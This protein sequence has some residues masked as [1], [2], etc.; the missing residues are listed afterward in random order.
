MKNFL[1]IADFDKIAIENLIQKA[2]IFKQENLFYNTYNN[3]IIVNL[4]FED[5]TR[6]RTSFEMAELRLGFRTIGFNPQTSSTNKGE[7]LED[8]CKTM[9]SIGVN[10]LV[11]RHFKN[12]FYDELKD[13]QIP[14]INAGDGSGEHPSQCL[15]DLLTI[16]EHFGYFDG[17]KVAIVGDISSSRVAKSNKIA[18]EKLGA[19]VSLVAPSIYQD[20]ALGDYINFDD[21]IEDVDVCMLLRIQHERHGDEGLSLSEYISLYS[22]NQARYE[23]LKQNS[24]IMHPAP[25]NRGVEIES[26]LVESPKS[27]IFTQMKNGVYARMAVL[28][29]VFKG[30]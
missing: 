17:L 8:T 18:L 3:K 2:L 10:A 6:T 30:E 16:K 14:V 21:C 5:S 1:R 13:L 26:H 23:K 12:A 24:I 29:Y 22:L 15:L 20:K 7:S 19:K 11:V 9:Q 25:V 27:R 4:F 28:D